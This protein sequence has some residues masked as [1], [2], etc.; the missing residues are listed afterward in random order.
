MT[1]FSHLNFSHRDLRNQSFKG[2]NLCGADF[3]GADIRGC[4][5]REAMLRGANFTGVK[6]GVSRGRI[7]GLI[8]RCGGVAIAVTAGGAVGGIWGMMAT[9]LVAIA[10]TSSERGIIAATIAGMSAY[11]GCRGL[12]I[13]ID[14]DLMR[15]IFFGGFSIVVFGMATLMF[16]EVVKEM[17]K[18]TVTSFEDA[19]LTDAIFDK[20]SQQ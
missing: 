8:G 6:L 15:G 9:G 5:F 17:E 11:L 18:L 19:D 20:I 4:D 12:L 10:I 3:S 14:G 1:E 2:Q 13:F 16:L 7:W